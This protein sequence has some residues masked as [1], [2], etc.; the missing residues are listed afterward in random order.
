MVLE[1]YWCLCLMF[2]WLVYVFRLFLVGLV[3]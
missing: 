3:V 2:G 1:V